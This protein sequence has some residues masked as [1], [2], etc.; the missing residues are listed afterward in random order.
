MPEP[1]LWNSAL[2]RRGFLKTTGAASLATAIAWHGFRTEVMAVTYSIVEDS[3]QPGDPI[4][5]EFSD[6]FTTFV[7]SFYDAYADPVNT[8][9]VIAGSYFTEVTGAGASPS[10]GPI[11]ASNFTPPPTI[12]V[13][14]ETYFRP[15]EVEPMH[16]EQGEM[17][18]F[19]VPPP[20]GWLR[21]RIGDFYPE[22]PNW[23]TATPTYKRVNQ[24][25]N[26]WAVSYRYVKQ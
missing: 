21:C 12:Q 18:D 5:I 6:H 1:N 14:D 3:G 4:V 16:N 7:A 2:G 17:Y 23:A 20:A 11:N 8:S 15:E 19:P 25:Y 22:H 9:G 26:C 10:D 24:Q 13:D